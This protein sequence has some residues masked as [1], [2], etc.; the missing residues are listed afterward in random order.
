MH[1]LVTFSKTFNSLAI[2][3]LTTSHGNHQKLLS[4]L[5]HVNILVLYYS[6]YPVQ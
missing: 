6:Y 4:I 5:C 2:V 3:K 1:I